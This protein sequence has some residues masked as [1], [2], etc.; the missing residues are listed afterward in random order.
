MKEKFDKLRSGRKYKCFWCGHCFIQDTKYKNDSK[1]GVVSS[2]VV[3]PNCA[4]TIP[5]SAK[6]IFEDKV[7]RK[8]THIRNWRG[9]KMLYG[10]KLIHSTF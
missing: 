3:C 7:G 10:I 2:I 4:R 5:N 1:K 9:N 8:H 6:E